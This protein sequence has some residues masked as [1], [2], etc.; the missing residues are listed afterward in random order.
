M[1][2]GIRIKKEFLKKKIIYVE[3]SIKS[4]IKTSNL[5]NKQIPSLKIKLLILDDNSTYEN[6]NRIKNILIKAN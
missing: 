6:L 2:F 4:L 3:K 5:S 1:K